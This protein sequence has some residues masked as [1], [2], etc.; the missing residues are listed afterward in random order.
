MAE[1]E[2]HDHVTGDDSVDQIV[3]DYKGGQISRRSF[4][5]RAVAIGIAVPTAAGILAACGGDDS[6]EPAPAEEP[7]APADDPPAPAEDPPPPADDPP[8][9]A[10]D[11]PPPA[12]PEAP[13]G[14]E[15]VVGGELIEGYDLDFSRMDPING[16]WYDPAWFALYES[17][18]TNNPAGELE[19]GLAES[20]EFAEDGLSLTFKI[21]PDAVFHS[22]RP[23]TAGAIKEEFDVI[24]DPASGSPLNSLVVTQVASY[25]APDDTTFV[26]NF[27][28]PY[29]GI[30]NAVKTGFWRIVNMETRDR[31]GPDDYGL[32][33]LDGSGPF[34]MT[35]FTPGD[36]VIVTRN[37]AYPGSITPYHQNS[38]TAYLDSV[39][40]VTIL[41][42]AQRAIQLETGEID[43]LRGPNFP[44]IDRLRGNDEI[45][46]TELAEWSGYTLHTNWDR[47]DLGW[48]DVR[49]RQ[50][51]SKAIDRQAIVDNIFFGF[52][53]PLFGPV[54]SAAETY[55]PGVEEFNQFS[56]D[57][58]NA[59][60]VEAGW[61][62]GDD[63][64]YE[65]DGVRQAFSLT[66]QTETFNDQIA[67]A[68]QEQLGELGAEV[69]I[70]SLDRG[71]F[72]EVLFGN[73]AEMSLFFYL[74]PVPIDVIIVFA[75]GSNAVADS[76]GPNF[77]NARSATVDAAIDTYFR[78]SN[79]EE[80]QQGAFD[81]QTVAAEELPFIPVVNRS[82]FWANR[83][84]IRNYVVH[85]WN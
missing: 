36:K 43:T 57:E 31:L 32:T 40:W 5:K 64:I 63:G 84:N 16:S 61:T 82:A 41:E 21:R 3:D 18:L 80:Y 6:A 39:R 60:M 51:L 12:E 66:I 73:E 83:N 72:F 74:W 26:I 15:P 62:K 4:M 55:N 33:E 25:E 52:G 50:A 75:I 44:D 68:V 54:T 45:T 71:S 42:A 70:N 9:P 47:T 28:H 49:V 78:S 19:P 58:A 34:T 8:P 2:Q 79:A 37:D 10:D 20:W 67:A 85:Q 7:P 14:E 65:K 22:G 13:A 46:V 1:K 56:L 69:T 23:L 11:P 59:L 27:N 38:G 29:F 53:E 30:L 17:L 24:Q 76:G 35:E 81:L 48:D 77:S